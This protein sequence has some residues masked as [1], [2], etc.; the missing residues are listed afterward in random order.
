MLVDAHCHLHEVK[1]YEIKDVIPV[2]SG[3]SHASNVKT[4]GLAKK[5]KLPFSLGIAP[6]SVIKLKGLEELDG[7]LEYIRKQKP[8]A[9]GE[10]GLDYHW[11][12]EK[13]EIER[14]QITF[15]QAVDLAIEM[16][17][18]LV[19]HSRDATKDVIDTL[20]LKAF[21]YRFMFH[22]FSGKPSDAKWIVEQNG[23]ISITPLHSK[24]R[25]AAIEQ[26]PLENLVVE[27]DA[28]YVGRTPDAVRE[29]VAYISEVKKLDFEEVAEQT[30]GN[31]IRFFN[32]RV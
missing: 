11:A 23:L 12:K 25:R 17:L 19:I 15:Y 9:I 3:Y 18:P 29:S 1:D 21:P 26:T 20:K 7:W 6:Q 22:F 31:A 13:T 2:G 28:P 32:F 27:T 8:N 5:L 14:E 10:V 30:A 16:K 24:D 4:A